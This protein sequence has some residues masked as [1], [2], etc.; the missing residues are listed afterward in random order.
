VRPCCGE[1][2]G[3]RQPRPDVAPVPPMKISEPLPRTAPGPLARVQRQPEMVVDLTP[4]LS[5]IQVGQRA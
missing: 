3:K 4:G 5:E 2:S 1:R